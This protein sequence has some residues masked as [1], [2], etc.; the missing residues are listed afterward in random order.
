MV[1]IP[2][3]PVKRWNFRKADWNHYCVLTDQSAVQLTSPDTSNADEAYQD[4]CNVIIAAAKKTIPHGRRNNYMPCWDTEC[5]SLYRSYLNAPPGVASSQAATKLLERL[6]AKRLE[7]W[8]EAVNTID[9]SHSS[10]KAWSTINNLAG[11]SKRSLRQ[12]PVTANAIASQLVKNGA[13]RTKDRTTSHRLAK[14]VSDLWR[15]ETP[16]DGHISGDFT[17]E[18]FV[19]AL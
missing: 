6:D 13:Y 12:C 15:V 1:P 7:R 5:E 9:F 3:T 16:P 8:T 18:E 17:P 19:A 14:E 4:F 2:S 11:R 10:R